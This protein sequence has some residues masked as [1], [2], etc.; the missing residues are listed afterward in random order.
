MQP[1]VIEHEYAEELMRR[2]SQLESAS[3]SMG[4]F[5]RFI[6]TERIIKRGE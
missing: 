2:L 6:Q 4:D 5:I 1:L 3:K